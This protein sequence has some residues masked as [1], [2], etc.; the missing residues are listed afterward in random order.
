MSVLIAAYNEEKVIARTV[1]SILANGYEDLEIV[2]VD[3]GSKDQTLSVL[4]EHFGD[5]RA[6]GS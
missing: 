1:E 5:N 2:V 3:D 4:R 6:F